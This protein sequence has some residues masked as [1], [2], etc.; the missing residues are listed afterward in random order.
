MTPRVSV[1]V[2][3][4]NQG[5]WLGEALDSALAQ[6]FSD[7][8]IIVVDDGSTDPDTR[9]ALDALDRPRTRV[10]RIAN[11]GLPGARNAGI[12]EAKGEFVCCLDSDDV[13]E[14]TLLE[15]SIALLD[16][17]P[18]VTFVS[19]WL[20]TFGDESWEWTPERCDFPALLD[21]NTVNGA[22][23]V[24]RQALLDAGLFDETMTG[25]CED[26][27][28]WIT[29]V[30]RGHVGAILPEFL[31]RYRRRADSMSRLMARAGGNVALYE[32]LA[33]KHEA[34]YRRHLPYL[35]ARRAEVAA[36]LARHVLELRH[37]E[38]R[39]LGPELARKREHAAALR[40]KAER[41]RRA[42]ALEARAAEAEQSAARAAYQGDLA[43]RREREAIRLGA[44]VAELIAEKGALA[45]AA[46][47][48]AEGRRA[49]LR[50]LHASLSWRLTAPLRALHAVLTG[51]GR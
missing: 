30:E 46:S 36:G 44:R 43:A 21:A 51:R 34:S 1:V 40:E 26:W 48:E 18:D 12:R 15:K 7:L 13:L 3:C 5:A 20:R 31:F 41:A 35:Y 9:A 22:A 32:R 16:A 42:A 2:P 39:W 10:L 28:L 50:R 37:E 47:A 25:G 14:P 33:R 27:D 38:E 4:Y 23:P 49:D 8:E 29:L 11:R 45:A 17:R 6:T 19:H 24:R